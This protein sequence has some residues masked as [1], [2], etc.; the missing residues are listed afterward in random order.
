MN[1]NFK[2]KYC[3]KIT[4]TQGS[5]KDKIYFGQHCTNNL[6]DGYKGRGRKLNDYY[7]VYPDGYI[8]EILGFYDTIEELD[9][10]E[11]DLIHPHLGKDYCLNLIEGGHVNRMS[12]ELKQD[13]SN[14]TKE[15]MKNQEIRN[16]CSKGGKKHKGYKWTEEERKKH[17]NYYKENGGNTLGKKLWPNGRTFSE[18]W[19]E[20][21]KEACNTK[22]N[23]EHLRETTKEMW[24]HK[25]YEERKEIGR[26][27]SKANKGKPSAIKGKHKVW[28]NKDKKIYHYE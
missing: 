13:I 3:Y 11:Y 28:D 5:L 25:T 12:E 6:D 26:K 20:K 16:K 2:F 23:I 14:K 19:Y 1:K 15:A 22:E 18:E 7:K 17:E 21:H 9:K 4:L 8:K 24:A 10:A 27:I